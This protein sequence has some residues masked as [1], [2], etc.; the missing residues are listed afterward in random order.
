MRVF[1]KKSQRN[2]PRAEVPTG[3]VEY[4]A[5]ICLRTEKGIFFLN[6]DL[7]RYRIAT[8]RILQSWNFPLIVDSSEA[9]ASTYPIAINKLGF[10]DGSLLNNIADGKLYLVSAGKLRHIV[11]PDFLNRIGKTT[12][13]A[14]VV[15]DAEIKIMKV[16]E[17]IT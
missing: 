14:V 2:Q 8:D 5:G 10:R 11:N 17:K 3:P 12:A 16:G 6:K 15:S 9:A 7:K 1:K 4:P 13:E